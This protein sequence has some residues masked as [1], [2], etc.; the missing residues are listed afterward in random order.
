MR[1]SRWKVLLLLGFAPPPAVPHHST[2]LNCNACF[3]PFLCS[4]GKTDTTNRAIYV[5]QPSQ[6]MPYAE[7]AGRT[8]EP[9]SRGRVRR[10]LPEAGGVW[11]PSKKLPPSRGV[12][13]HGNLGWEGELHHALELPVERLKEEPRRCEAELF[14]DD[15]FTWVALR[16]SQSWIRMEGVDPSKKIMD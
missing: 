3:D 12:G 6:Q 16:R 7:G 4:I 9:A 11:L 2:G 8:T 15:M 13:G 5:S 10:G 1:A 14:L